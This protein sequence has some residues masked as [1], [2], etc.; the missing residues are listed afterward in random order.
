MSARTLLQIQRST[1]QVLGERHA[2]VRNSRFRNVVICFTPSYTILVLTRCKRHQGG[3]EKLDFD[4][5][6]YFLYTVG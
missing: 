1:S 2:A 3:C 6:M 4:S 5:L